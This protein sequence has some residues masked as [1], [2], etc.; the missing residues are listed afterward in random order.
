M[1]QKLIYFETQPKYIFSLLYL[2]NRKAPVLLINI[3]N[4]GFSSRGNNLSTGY[5]NYFSKE[6]LDREG[7]FSNISIA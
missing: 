7:H 5:S 3:I 6:T 4:I 1:K 2:E